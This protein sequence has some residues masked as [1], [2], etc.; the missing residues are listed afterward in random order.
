[1]F[2]RIFQHFRPYI[3]SSKKTYADYATLT[4]IHGDVLNVMTKTYRTYNK[5]PSALYTSAVAA[6]KK[7]ESVRKSIAQLLS[8]SS[9]HSVHADEIYFT[10]G[11]TESNNIAIL[12]VIDA[13]YEK[14]SHV[15]HVVISDIEHPAVKKVIEDLVQKKRVTASY[16]PVTSQGL[17][18]LN[19]LKEVLHTQEHVVLVSI[20]FVNN[21]IGTIQPLKEIARAVRAYRKNNNSL[22]PYIHTDAC[23]APAYVDMPIDQL[24]IDMMTLDGGKIY[25]PRGVGCLYV[26]KHV[27]IVSSHK[28]GSQEQGLRPG[29]ENLPAIV[30]FEKALSYVLHVKRSEVERFREMQAYIYHHL[31]E[32]VYVNGATEH[33]KRIV[34]NINV[35]FP[36]K[37]SEFLVFQADVA[38]VELSAVTACQ[39]VQ[40]ESRSTV[41]DALGKNCGA[42]SLRI[43]LGLYTTWKD[44]KRIVSVMQKLGKVS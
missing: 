7:L 15:P 42:S 3:G 23:Q 34:N 37:D 26:K 14:S 28:G 39:N 24:G 16:I 43:S 8:G 32:C 13:W 36:G 30:G 2:S 21:E 19:A 10:S 31:P 12:G 9:L 20:M 6:K 17:I 33:E 25:G 38:G 1:M 35:C 22:Y 5:N 11:G 27:H 44:V 29:T 40:E 18:D 41:V 4:P